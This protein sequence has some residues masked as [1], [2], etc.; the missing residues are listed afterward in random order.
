MTFHLILS[1]VLPFALA[2]REPQSLLTQADPRTILEDFLTNG[3]YSEERHSKALEA[4]SHLN[5]ETFLSAA[6]KNQ[7]NSSAC[8]DSLISL[9]EDLKNSKSYALSG[10]LSFP[11]TPC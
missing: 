6:L 8:V 4:V 11:F 9:G 10:K 5:P 2:V 3:K 1:L 7:T